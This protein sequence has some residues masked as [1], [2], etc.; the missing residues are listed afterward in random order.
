[1][2]R[3]RAE[4]RI[5]SP[6][7]VLYCGQL[8]ERKGLGDLIPAFAQAVGEGVD[9]SLLVVGTGRKEL[10]FKELAKRKGVAG[11]V[12][13]AGFVPR[14]DLPP[15]YA[16]AHLMALPS[17]QEVWGLVVNEALACG[18][19]VLSTDNVGAAADLIRDGVNGYVVPSGDSGSLAAALK[20]HFADETDR[21]AMKARARESIKP[22]S[23]ATAAD[24]F[25]QA[26]KCARD[27]VSRH[28][29]RGE[30]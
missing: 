1:V 14:E 6:F 8:I 25:E 4:Y 9:M 5:T 7:L 10:L 22:F 23:L 30:D 29:Y 3:I 11:R 13:F 26:V 2:A 24:A 12:V 21:D 19:P 17:R 15:L 18:T 20:R 16:T 27:H 28:Q